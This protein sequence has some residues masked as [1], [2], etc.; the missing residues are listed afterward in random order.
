[1]I[2]PHVP[3]VRT[4]RTFA[5]LY[6]PPL[7]AARWR[8]GYSGRAAAKTWQY[9][10]ALLVH[11]M[12]ARRRILCAREYLSSIRD[13]VHRLLADQIAALALGGFYH[14]QRDG[15][16]G[17][18]GTEFLFHGIRNNVEEFKGIEG[19]DVCWLE[20]ARN[21]SADSLEIVTPTIRK[22][23]SEIWATW[24]PGEPTDPIWQHLVVHPPPRSIV[25]KHSYLENPYASH[26]T[27]EEAETLRRRD[28]EAYA[29][30]WGGE[31]WQRSE[32][33]VF[34]GRY[35]VEDLGPPQPEWGAPLFGGDFGFSTDPAVLVK[36]YLF[37]RRLYIA[38]EAGGAQL[39]ADDL[40]RTWDTIPGARDYMIWADEARP[41]TIAEMRRRGFN[42]RAAPKWAGSVKDGIEHLRGSYDE[43]VIHP[44]CTLA[45]DNFRL[46]RYKAD[47]RTGAPLPELA[48][49]NDHVPDAVRYA[50]TRIIRRKGAPR[51]WF[52]G[53]KETDD[54]TEDAHA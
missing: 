34:A 37:A 3:V 16:F 29:H 53:M 35:R 26:E 40:E 42:V 5:Y 22:P 38:A 47:K 2:A 24:N 18:N 32:L 8:A 21:I 23:G 27:I 1:M 12:E 14:V 15:I 28:P 11:G 33:Q 13:S 52:P 30:I 31:P 50:L 43:I 46:Y 17:D 10:R 51:V 44:S 4:P 36:V 45:I 54:A 41:E 25:R 9:G 7:G 48:K 20:E 39:L 6:D 49:G 19:V